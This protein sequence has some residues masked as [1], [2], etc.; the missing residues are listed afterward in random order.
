LAAYARIPDD[1]KETKGGDSLA[2]DL[3]CA[4]TNVCRR[5]VKHL[6]EHHV[7]QSNTKECPKQLRLQGL[8]PKVRSGVVQVLRRL[9]QAADEGGERIHPRPPTGGQIVLR[10][11]VLLIGPPRRAE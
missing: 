11:D 10:A 9:A 6:P 1:R 2:D 3:R 7:G 5:R 8:D 4:G